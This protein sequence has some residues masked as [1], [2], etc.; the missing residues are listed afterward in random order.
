MSL[1]S[2]TT[3]LS[4][5][6]AYAPRVD[7]GNNLAVGTRN[8]ARKSISYRRVVETVHVFPPSLMPV[9]G[10]REIAPIEHAL[11]HAACES[12]HNANRVSGEPNS[13]DRRT[14]NL[15]CR[16]SAQQRCTID[17][18]HRTA[19]LT[20]RAIGRRPKRLKIANNVV[21]NIT[22]AR[23]RQRPVRCNRLMAILNAPSARVSVGLSSSRFARSRAHISDG[24]RH[25]SCMRGV[26]SHDACGR[27]A[28]N[29]ARSPS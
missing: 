21:R 13:D 22:N 6:N 11:P 10:M 18:P 2:P 5:A 26:F 4:A 27:A 23:G 29:R 15:Q 24:A 9:P 25:H 1:K 12:R 8:P 16:A 19:R 7:E 3:S 17:L 14:G 28:E 20:G